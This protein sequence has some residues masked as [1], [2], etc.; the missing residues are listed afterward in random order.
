MKTGKGETGQEDKARSRELV[1][2][3]GQC[4]G[5]GTI[6]QAVVAPSHPTPMAP[7]GAVTLARE[8]VTGDRSD[9]RSLASF[10]PHDKTSCLT[11]QRQVVR[12]VRGA[13][14]GN[15]RR[16]CTPPSINMKDTPGQLKTGIE[17]RVFTALGQ[18]K[19]S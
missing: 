17:R 5:V 18:R 15:T 16:V 9:R 2:G 6:C 1:G 19:I 3:G 12:G 7:T 10:H 13:V 8:G 11:T 14:G 4:R